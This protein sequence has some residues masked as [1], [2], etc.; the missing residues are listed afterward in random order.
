MVVGAFPMAKLLYLG[1][2]QVSK[3]LANRIKEAAR[4]SEFFKT[5]IC[6]PPAQLYH[7]AEMRT[8]MRIMGFNAEAVKPLNEGAAAELGAELLGE[9]I[10]FVTAC[11]CLLMEYLRQQAQR[12]RKEA[13]RRAAWNALRDEMGHLALAL[14]T[15]QGQVQATPAKGALEELRQE[16]REV[17]AQLHADQ[18]RN[19]DPLPDLLEY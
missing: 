16:L 15:L 11:G 4:R 1:I 12:R 13:E 7:W 14:E 5:Y 6:L 3:P 2:R 9:A 19:P 8:K 10:I 17:R 18:D